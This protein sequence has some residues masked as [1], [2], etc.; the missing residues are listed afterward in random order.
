[1][2]RRDGG[3]NTCIAHINNINNEETRARE[4]ASARRRQRYIQSVRCEEAVKK[5]SLRYCVTHS[6]SYD[7]TSVCTARTNAHASRLCEE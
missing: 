2:R 4:P 5:I 3:N 1:M 6:G 7:L